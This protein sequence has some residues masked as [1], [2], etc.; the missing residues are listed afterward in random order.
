LSF[1]TAQ[2]AGYV[3]DPV[4]HTLTWTR[5]GFTAFAQFSG[6]ATFTL[7][8]QARM[9][10]TLCNEVEI[11]P[12]AS[13]ATPAN[14]RHSWCNLIT[15]SWDPNDKRV[16]PHRGGDE[17]QGGI[18][19]QSDNR[20]DYALRF[21]NT[22]NDVAYTVVIRDTLDV[23]HLSL[24]SIRVSGAS[25]PYRL[26]LEGGNILTIYFMDINLPDSTS[27][28]LGSMGYFNFSI[29]LKDN[30]PLGTRIDNRVAIFFDFNEPV[31]TNTVQTIIGAPVSVLERSSLPQGLSIFPN[32]ARNQATVRWTLSQ[33]SEGG[34]LQLLDLQGRVLRQY[35]LA[36]PMQAAEAYQLE[37]FDLQGLPAGSYFV[38]LQTAQSSQQAMLIIKD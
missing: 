13:D 25:H 1:N 28:P 2:P 11:Q 29:D 31:I 6:S 15:N 27:D 34:Q 9:G 17:Y 24:S 33:G 36:Q 26:E 14:N 3:H 19:Y 23:N 22:G 20:L 12:I 32:P 21:Q 16:Y 35:L 38:R 4:N 5:N 37:Q 10:D 30:L 7:S 18:A 8:Q